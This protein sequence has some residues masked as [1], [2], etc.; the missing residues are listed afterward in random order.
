MKLSE[1]NLER[2]LLLKYNQNLIGWLFFFLY[3]ALFVFNLEI[4]CYNFILSKYS[5]LL[6]YSKLLDY[7]R[8]LELV[9]AS[10]WLLEYSLAPLI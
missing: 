7:S 9:L 8:V 5:K 2:E 1:L 3:F 4:N 6:A 10:N